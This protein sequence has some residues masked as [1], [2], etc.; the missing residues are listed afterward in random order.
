VNRPPFVMGIDVGTTAV[1]VAVVSK[2]GHV[3]ASSSIAYGTVSPRPGW[4]EQDPDV[5]WHS[6]VRAVRECLEK[7]PSG[8]IEAVSFSGHMSATVLVGRDGV[9]AM[10]SILIADT[11]S[12]DETEWLK[13][14]M[15]ARI[16]EMTGNEPLDA[17]SLP[18]LMW[19]RRHR[20][21]VLERASAFLFPKDYIRFRMSGDI[22]TDY[23][24]A[25]NSQL[26]HFAKKRWETDLAEELG[27]DSRLLPP[28][29][30]SASVV[31]R[32]CREAA[33]LTGLAEGT[34]VV[35]GAADMACSQLGTGAFEEGTMAIT[36]STSAQVVMRVPT[37]GTKS[38][39]RITLHPSA[40]PDTYYAMGSIFT[41]GLGVEW[42]YRLLAGKEKLEAAD[43]QKINE[44][45]NRMREIPAGSG[46]VLFL[47]FLT[48]SGTPHFD[49]RDKASWLGLSLGQD[50]V[51]LLHSV[52]E[53][54]AYNIRE[55]VEVFEDE[56]RKIRIIHLGGGGS[57]NPV[58]CQIISN[59]LGK[60]IRL[61]TVRDAS[62]MGAAML[63]GAGVGL[64][65]SLEEAA[66]RMVKTGDIY[67][68]DGAA[69]GTYDI[70]YRRYR[71]IYRVLNEYYRDA[72]GGAGS[73]GE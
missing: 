55:N 31:G 28:L 4:V 19:I 14:N 44:W 63:A 15:M 68:C 71:K 39:G 34:P 56:G 47:P 54:I 73:S 33:E 66:S 58:W 40:I 49:S 38:A 24:D 10:P 41:G 2:D 62:V 23:T 57:K 64:F 45:S 11:R 51:L 3:A 59:V 1:K 18:K 22:G 32:V 42:G 70:L 69:A 53:G 30:P 35:A 7:L 48:G 46:G 60:D 12:R 25:G 36:L 37:V 20:P 67:A 50:A 13:Q 52:M 17:F 26:F 29:F 27:L 65:P 72:A 16:L 61:L 6:T 43:F 21:E 9:P 8:R 5:W